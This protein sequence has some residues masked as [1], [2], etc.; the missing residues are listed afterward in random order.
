MKEEEEKESHNLVKI[1]CKEYNL[2][3]KELANKLDIPNGTIGRWASGNNIPK[4]ADIAL[5]LMLENKELKD[6]LELLKI[7]K[8]ALMNI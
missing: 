5:K 2:S 7:F 1:V 6:K 4:T 8:K 3:Q